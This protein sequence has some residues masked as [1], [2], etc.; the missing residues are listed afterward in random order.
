MKD[1]MKRNTKIALTLCLA[2]FGTAIQARADCQNVSGTITETSIP[3]PNDPLGRSLANVYGTLNGANQHSRGDAEDRRQHAAH[4]EYRPPRAGQ[5]AVG[6]RQ[7]A[8]KLP[9]VPVA[10]PLECLPEAACL[11][12]GRGV[13]HE[14]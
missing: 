2:V 8:N 9:L 5:P 4:H 7:D 14:R 10:E 6:L 3:A 12:D 13:E 11:R 1:L